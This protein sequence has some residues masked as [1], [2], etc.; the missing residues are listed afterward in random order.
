MSGIFPNTN[1]GGLAPNASD[2][3]N[4]SHA[5]DPTVEPQDTSA[6]YYGN[7]CDVRLRPEVVNSLISELEAITDR[8]GVAYR[9]GRL[10]NAELAIRYM[11]QRGLPKATELEGGPNLYNGELDP[12]MTDYNDFMVLVVVPAVTNV[13]YVRISI[14]GK[15]YVRVLRNDRQELRLFDWEAGIPQ[16]IGFWNGDFYLLGLAK[17]QVYLRVTDTLNIWIRTDGSDTTGDGTEN[18]PAKAYRTINRAW[19]SLLERFVPTPTSNVNLWL[20]IPGIYESGSI[21]PFGSGY[22]SLNGDIANHTGYRIAQQKASSGSCLSISGPINC[23]VRGVTMHGDLGPGNFFPV[24]LRVGP[25][26]RANLDRIRCECMINTPEQI[27]IQIQSG[28]VVPVPGT[29]LEFR[30]NGTSMAHGIDCGFSSTWGAQPPPLAPA[31][32]TFD[33]CTYPV[34]QNIQCHT[35]SSFGMGQNNIT[36]AVINGRKFWVGV[37]SVIYAGGKTFPGSVAGAADSATFGSYIP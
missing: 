1:D 32:L 35:L 30:G 20:G 3:Q 21:G 17:S 23:T 10:T 37:N 13:G 16:I 31:L 26:A 28:L 9:A 27:F 29:V 8:G 25:G 19:A 24:M 14:D 11:I 33:S 7:G 34:G 2:P 22:V 4:P 5:Y 6:L 36:G 18:T 15:P 12:V